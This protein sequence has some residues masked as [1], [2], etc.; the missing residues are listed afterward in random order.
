[1]QALRIN[2]LASSTRPSA[3]GWLLLVAGAMAFAV[4]W[5]DHG[6][7]GAE[8]A[9]VQSRLAQ[10]APAPR[11]RAAPTS[12]VGETEAIKARQRA[13]AQLSLPWARWLGAL[14]ALPGQRVALLALDLQGDAATVRLNAEARD[15]RQALAYLSALRASPEVASAELSTH[16]QL[17][18]GEADVLRF[19]I[20]LRWKAAP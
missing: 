17:R 3:L 2:V 8:R 12:A 10:K 11:A 14:E 15:I 4:A 9:L 13:M 18:V 5:W 6:D 1:M 19:T 20:D 16:E 7:A